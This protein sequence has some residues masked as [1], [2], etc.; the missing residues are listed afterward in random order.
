M[1]QLNQLED[2]QLIA[3]AAQRAVLL[4]TP[5]GK[6]SAEPV[7]EHTLNRC[8]Q[9]GPAQVSPQAPHERRGGA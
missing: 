4:R 1:K 3:L 8:F 7:E 2:G 6:C 5:S 9:C